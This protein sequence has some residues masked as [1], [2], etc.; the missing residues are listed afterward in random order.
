MAEAAVVLT[1]P[2]AVPSAPAVSSFRG[3]V[4]A[5]DLQEEIAPRGEWSFAALAGR[6]VEISGDGRL[7]LTVPLLVQAQ[8]EREPV[9]WVSAAKAVF[10][11]PDMAAGGVNLEALPVIGVSTAQEAALVADRLIRSGAFGLVVV[12]LNDDMRMRATAQGR[13]AQL[14]RRHDTALVCLSVQGHLR[15]DGSSMVSLRAESR[16]R[17]TGSARFRCELQA[18]KDKRRGPGWS[19]AE[20]CRG[21]SGLR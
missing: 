9:A 2:A 14:A 17:R 7:T 12:D 21:P 18:F 8:R 15:G 4:R 11:P 13:L 16:R 1:P 10:F 20:V 3:L 5:A 6:L 19:H